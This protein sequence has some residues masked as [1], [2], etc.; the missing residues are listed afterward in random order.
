MSDWVVIELSS[1][2]EDADPEVL[3]QVMNKLLNN[4]RE[5]FVPAVTYVKRG[6]STTLCYCQG[7]VFVRAGL[8][9]GRYFDL[10]N[11]S[12]FTSVLSYQDEDK[13]YL[14]LL[15]DDK[16]REIQDTLRKHTQIT[17]EEGAEV[18]ITSGTYK[19]LSGECMGMV[20]EDSCSVKIQMRSI[21]TFV[22]IPVAMLRL[23]TEEDV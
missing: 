7:Y 14:R 12:F 6:V 9:S 16:V 1:S 21:L 13:T 8:P 23:K 10:L 20:T 22:Q 5:V 4:E 15:G 19:D 11:H 18:V 2:G 3:M 17:F